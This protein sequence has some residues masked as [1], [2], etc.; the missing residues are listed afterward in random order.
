MCIKLNSMSSVMHEVEDTHCQV[1]YSLWQ[2]FYLQNASPGGQRLQGEVTGQR[3][4]P[5]IGTQST[6]SIQYYRKPDTFALSTSG[7]HKK[8]RKA[9]KA[10]FKV[11][12]IP[13]IS[14]ASQGAWWGEI[15]ARSMHFFISQNMGKRQHWWAQVS[16]WRRWLMHTATQAVT[17]CMYEA[18]RALLRDLRWGHE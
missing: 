4:Y 7:K 2:S 3:R 16:E 1:V 15:P 8:C 5:R 9:T 6:W 14:P 11:I 13:E 18:R 10:A 17:E 12:V